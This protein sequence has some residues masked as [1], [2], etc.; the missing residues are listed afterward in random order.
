MEP[1]RLSHGGHWIYR[2][3]NRLVYALGKPIKISL[4]KAVTVVRGVQGGVYTHGHVGSL[5][6]CSVNEGMLPHFQWEVDYSFWEVGRK[7]E[8]LLK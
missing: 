2:Y 8:L 6:H 5:H 4:R 3:W 7:L 1:K